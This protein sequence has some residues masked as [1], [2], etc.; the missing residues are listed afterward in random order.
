MTSPSNLSIEEKLYAATRLPQPRPEFLAGLRMRLADE[1]PYPLSLEE[2][3]KMTFRRTTTMAALSILAILLAAFVIVGPQ[4]VIAA[5]QQLIGYIPGIG[6]VE[7]TETVRVLA[8]PVSVTQD[9]ITMTVDEAVA[10]ANSTRVNVRVDGPSDFRKFFFQP[11]AEIPFGP[12]RLTLPDGVEVTLRSFG[13]EVDKTWLIFQILY[14]A[15]PDQVNDATLTIDSIPATLPGGVTGTWK[16]PLH[17]EPGQNDARMTGATS[18]SF[19]S[20][21][22]NGITMSLESA[23]QTDRMDALKIS[24]QTKDPDLY[25]DINWENNLKLEDQ[26]GQTLLLS[27]TAFFV[28]DRKDVVTLET[29][30]LMPGEQ[31]TLTLQGPIGV[32]R[33]VPSE[34]TTSRFSLDLGSNPHPGQSWKLDQTL[35]AAGKQIHLTGAHLL[36][37]NVCGGPSYSTSSTTSLTFDFDFGSGFTNLMVVTTDADSKAW[38]S[39]EG[40]CIVYPE[41]PSGLLGFRISTVTFPVEGTWEIPWQAPEK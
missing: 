32:F 40:G 10:D 30:I 35:E 8:E 24:L 16:I 25:I 39:Y 38:R 29:P 7:D 2:R 28:E 27:P 9:G 18:L 22:V 6:F 31:Y 15:L 20:Q 11:G 19:S 33:N 17:F 23:A 21:E 26:D 36:S 1:R 12:H 41:L 4:K 3:L 5:V 14:N 37:S 13:V 34:D